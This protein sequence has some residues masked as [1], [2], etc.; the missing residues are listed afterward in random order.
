MGKRFGTGLLSSCCSR[1]EVKKWE[2]AW[3]SNSVILKNKVLLLIMAYL[4]TLFLMFLNLELDEIIKV[5]ILPTTNKFTCSLCLK[6]CVLASQSF[7]TSTPITTK[8]PLN[9]GGGTGSL[10]PAL[11][12]YWF[13]LSAHTPSI[14]C[15]RFQGRL[16]TLICRISSNSPFENSL[17]IESQY[18]MKS[19][20]D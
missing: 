5:P 3:W 11:G 13:L 10:S 12:Y 4:K 19:N 16:T 20:T 17:L 6:T 9:V 7:N 1:K 2:S 14:Y 15:L 18:L 8:Q